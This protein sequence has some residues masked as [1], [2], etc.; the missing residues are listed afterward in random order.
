MEQRKNKQQREVPEQDKKAHQRH[1]IILEAPAHLGDDQAQAASHFLHSAYVSASLSS[2][3]ALLFL[4][5][6]PSSPSRFLSPSPTLPSPIHFSTSSLTLFHFFSLFHSLSISR[7]RSRTRT[8]TLIPFPSLS[9]PLPRFLLPGF[10]K[11]S[12]DFSTKKGPRKN[13]STWRIPDLFCFRPTGA[14]RADAS[15]R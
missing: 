12:L 7:S 3:V 4:L 8:C 14:V 15:G 10:R 2:L 11:R 1:L 5:L 9:F 6:S 13:P